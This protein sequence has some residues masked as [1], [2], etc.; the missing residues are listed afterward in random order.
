MIAH[1]TSTMQVSDIQMFC[2]PA[3]A[4]NE[5]RIEAENAAVSAGDIYWTCA[6]RWMYCNDAIWTKNDI[7]SIN[8]VIEIICL[9]IILTYSFK[10]L[11]ILYFVCQMFF[12][13]RILFELHKDKIDLF[14]PCII[15]SHRVV[16]VLIGNNNEAKALE[17][18]LTSIKD[19]SKYPHVDMSL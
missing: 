7:S 6:I 3:E 18:I 12:K 16:T 14:F 15:M 13:A 8:E 10:F 1:N 19:C 9:A 17:N 2:E 4:A 11:L 5:V